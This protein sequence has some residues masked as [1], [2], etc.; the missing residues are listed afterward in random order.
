MTGVLGDSVTDQLGVI[1]AVDDKFAIDI[2]ECG[3]GKCLEDTDAIRAFDQRGSEEP[4]W[5]VGGTVWVFKVVVVGA[6]MWEFEIVAD[7]GG[8]G[9]EVGGFVAAADVE[10]HGRIVFLVFRFW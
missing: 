2:Q 6:W 8:W 1:V 5:T 9:F 7:A 10:L 4:V 3:F